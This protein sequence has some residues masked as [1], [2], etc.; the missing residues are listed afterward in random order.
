MNL[1]VKIEKK[2]NLDVNVEKTNLDIKTYI[3]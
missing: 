1:D 2:M 3:F